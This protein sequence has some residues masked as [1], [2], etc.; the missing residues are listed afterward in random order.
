VSKFVNL[1]NFYHFDPAFQALH[2]AEGQQVSGFQGKG[3][4]DSLAPASL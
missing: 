2:D 1:D 3:D 4:W